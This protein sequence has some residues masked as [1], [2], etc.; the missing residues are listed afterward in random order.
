MTGAMIGAFAISAGGRG[1]GGASVE[2]TGR[3]V[4]MFGPASI[5]GIVSL[6]AKRVGLFAFLLIWLVLR[7]DFTVVSFLGCPGIFRAREV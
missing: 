5:T 3:D 2:I 4:P 7:F 1:C 6:L